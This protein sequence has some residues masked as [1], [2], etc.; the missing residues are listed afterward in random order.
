MVVV[1]FSTRNPIPGSELANSFDLP[2]FVGFL[3]LKQIKKTEGFKK[4]S[5]P[6]SIGFP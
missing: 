4:S 1:G 6:E 3:N 5:L 2:K